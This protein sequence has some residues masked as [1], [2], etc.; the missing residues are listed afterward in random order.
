MSRVVFDAG[1]GGRD[2]FNVGPGGYVEADATLIMAT[3]AAKKLGRNG[4]EVDMTRWSDVDLAPSNR[5]WDEGIDL[6]NRCYIA[7]SKK[8]DYFVSIHTDANQDIT[9]HGTTVYCLRKG[10]EG[11]KLAKAIHD[12]VTTKMGTS[13][14]GV[15]EANFAVLRE[16]HMP[17]ALIEVGFHTNLNECAKLRSNLFLIQAGEAIADGVMDFLGIVPKDEVTPDINL[18]SI[19]M[20]SGRVM[21]GKIIDNETWAPV[22]SLITDLGRKVDWDGKKVIIS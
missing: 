16:T 10:G 2:R 14:R 19:Q 8:A 1:H 12:S 13:P 5:H 18:V 4:V 6:S 3:A 11:E 22:R 15:R 20:P 9:A 21:K 7:N 17:A